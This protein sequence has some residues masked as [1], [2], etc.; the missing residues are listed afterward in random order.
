[1][2]GETV[3]S[4]SG[5]SVGACADEDSS[6]GAQNYIRVTGTCPEYYSVNG[7]SSTYYTITFDANGGSLSTTSKTVVGGT[8]MGY[9]PTPYRLG[10]QFDGWFTATEEGV[11][12]TSDTVVNG[13]ITLYAH[14]TRIVLLEGYCGDNLYFILYADGGLEFSGYGDMTSH[15]WTNKYSKRVYEVS[16]PQEVTS[17]CA[18]AFEGCQYMQ[19]FDLP[20]ITTIP[21]KAFRECTSLE[22]INLPDQITIIS[23]YS[24]E[25]C[26]N[27]KTV[28]IPKLLKNIGGLAFASTAINSIEIPKSL[29]T[30][31]IAPYSW[32][33]D[34]GPFKNCNELKSVTI[35]NGSV[36]IPSH[37]FGGCTGIEEI[38]IPDTVTSIKDYAFYMCSNLSKV[39][40][41]KSLTH[42]GGLAFY[43][44]ALS[45]IEIPKSLENVGIAPYSWSNENGPFKNCDNLKTITFEKGITKIQNSLFAGCTGIEHITIPENFTSIG[46]YAF[47]NCTGLKEI[48]IPNSIK[49]LGTSVFSGCTSLES[50]VLPETIQSLPDNIFSGCT[51]LN[52]I[53]IPNTI[54]VIPTN[55]FN[56]CSALTDIEFPKELQSIK[57]NAFQNCISLKELYFPDSVEDIYQ[58]AFNHCTSLTKVVFPKSIK[59]IGYRAFAQCENLENLVFTNEVKS[60]KIQGYSFSE[61][62]K[63]KKVRLP[64]GISEINSYAFQKCS[65]LTDISIPSS[66]KAMGSYAFLNCELLENVLIADY[67]IK[68]VSDSTFKECLNLKKIVLPK[69]LTKISDFA[70][71][72]NTSLTEVEIPESV[73]SIATNAFSYPDIMT[74]YGYTESYAKQYCDEKGIT[75]V[76]NHVLSQGIALDQTHCTGEDYIIMDIGEV[77]EIA[78]EVYP[79]DSNDVISLTSDNT[80]VTIN[81]MHITSKYAGDSV[82]TATATSGIEY[83][84][85]IHNRSVKN[86]S[87]KTLPDNLKITQ[88]NEL[89]LTGFELQVN[90]NDNSNDVTDNYTIS[91]FD[92]DTIGVQTITVSYVGANGSTYKTTFNVEVV[93]PRGNLTGISIK[94]YPRKLKYVKYDALDLSGLIV[95]ENYDSGLEIEITDYKVT[96][97]NA[98]KLGKQTIKITKGEYTVTFEVEVTEKPVYAIGDTN[99]DGRINIR[100][101]T[102]IQRHIAE[103]EVFADEQIALADTNGDG[104]INISD[105]THLQMYLAEYDVVLG[106]Q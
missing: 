76:D 70:F 4:K 97:Y 17:L 46:D 57:F 44:T 61:C 101:V 69:G 78:F 27:L 92:K 94:Q 71:A 47:E 36:Q 65:S 42:I 77:K 102:A 5:A 41:S 40:L 103:L 106:K 18:S 19:P 50:T 67:S 89:D 58:D 16:M 8:A 29:E 1:M 32:S 99:L 9:S 86:V 75:F 90:Y 73:T 43:S 33:D 79:L 81:G 37:L 87:V 38:T 100:D 22:S 56:A 98:L 49:T 20:N 74:T 80:R 85:T 59:T 95:V 34:G 104:E 39:T 15:P 51:S 84:F 28:N 105:A 3:S 26:T 72:N 14:W 6:V 66:V 25:N 2:A 54:K 96:G 93:D 55:A 63:L 35:E 30:A 24:F 88:G 52:N 21:T 83:I 48:A 7:S 11:Q 23:D 13:N 68:E 45:S 91:G 82:I 12:Y 60:T 62:T 10:Y 53:I 64:N 31:G